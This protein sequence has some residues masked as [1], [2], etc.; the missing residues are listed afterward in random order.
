MGK[1]LPV[2]VMTL[3]FLASTGSAV[4][5]YEQVNTLKANPQAQAQQEV[6]ALVALV[7]ELILLP[8]D[9]T[10]TVAT[11]NDP[12]KLQDQVFFANATAGDKVLIYTTAK[13][14]ILYNPTTNKIVEVAPINIGSGQAAATTTDQAATD[15]TESNP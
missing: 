11:V 15:T 1:R 4:Y 13:K 14:A 2:M 9:E 3:L 12:T 5:F 6:A 7:G 8:A 10:P